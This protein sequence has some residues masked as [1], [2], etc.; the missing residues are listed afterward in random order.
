MINPILNRIKGNFLFIFLSTI[1]ATCRFE[2]SGIE[3]LYQAIESGKPLIGTSWH[4]MTMMVIGSLRKYIDLDSVVTII[5]DDYRGDILEIFANKIGIYPDKL[6]LDGDNSMETSRKLLRIIRQISSGRNFL[7]HP[8]GP[9]GPAY[10]VKPGLTAIAQKTG[11][12]IMP[13]GGYCRH[14]Y[15]WDRWD[16]YTWPLPFSKIQLY[17]AKPFTI[18]RDI[19]DL[20]PKNQELEIILNKAAFHAAADYYE[21]GRD[22]H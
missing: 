22:H 21:I 13:M 5:P 9:A 18:S 16:R 10:V 15:H 2:I 11:A 7:I 1:S 12:L 20:S 3:N 6:N 17:V 4:G 19:Q 14:A 8:D